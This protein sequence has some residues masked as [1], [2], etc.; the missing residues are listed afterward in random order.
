MW[1]WSCGLGRSRVWGGGVLP[2]RMCNGSQ[3]VLDSSLLGHISSMHTG[4]SLV[5]NYLFN[6]FLQVSTASLPHQL[7]HV[8]IDRW[9]GPLQE[10]SWCHVLQ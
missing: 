6:S 9:E 3:A 1:L 7:Q 10:F 2:T 4:Y 8:G 5:T